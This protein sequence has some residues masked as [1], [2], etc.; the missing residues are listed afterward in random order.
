M[1]RVIK[2]GKFVTIYL[3]DRTVLNLEGV[4]QEDMDFIISSSDEDI[5]TR[6]AVGLHEYNEKVNKLKKAKELVKHSKVVE[7]KDGKYT[8]PSLSE[9]SAP[10]Y[11]VKKLMKAELDGDSDKMTSYLN[12]WTLLCQNPNEKARNN[13]LWFLVTHD[14]KILK[15]GL[16]V[17]YRNVLNRPIKINKYTEKEREYITTIAHNIKKVQKKSLK[18]Y[19]FIKYKGGKVEVLHNTKAVRLGT[20]L[21]ES[22]T[23]LKEILNSL[24]N[25]EDEVTYTDAHTQRMIIKLGQPVQLDRELCDEDSNISCSRGL[26][27]AKKDWSDLGTFGNTTLMC[28]CNPANVVA[29]PK[30]YSYGKIRTCEYFPVEVAQYLDGKII[31]TVEDGDELDYFKVCYD[32]MVNNNDSDEFKMEV[33]EKVELTLTETLKSLEEIN[34][35]LSKNIKIKN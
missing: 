30:E 19:S 15:S 13:L 35:I 7:F 11:L 6:F 25:L 17:A 8:I 3:A 5:K 24:N 12:F 29:V 33:P 26:H 22:I 10:K 18:N 20:H 1:G 31:E 27:L 32:G 14:F 16:F 23:D 28:L 34:E 4:S 21:V 2:S 9:V